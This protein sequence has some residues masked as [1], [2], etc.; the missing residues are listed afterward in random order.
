ML[1]SKL[2]AAASDVRGRAIEGA[3]FAK[4]GKGDQAGALASFKDL[5]SIEAK[6]YKELGQYHEAR[7]LAAQGNKDKA[8]ELLKAVRDKLQAPQPDGSKPFRFLE[9]MVDRKLAEIDPTAVPK[10]AAAAAPGGGA[11]LTPEQIEM[12]KKQFQ[13]AAQDAANKKQPPGDKPADK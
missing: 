5:Q 13:K 11:Q 1:S 10:A 12:L 2:A 8:K 4:E 9:A 3:G 6:G 7:V